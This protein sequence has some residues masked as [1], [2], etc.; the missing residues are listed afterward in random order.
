MHSIIILAGVF[1]VAAALYIF[2]SSR[3]D[4]QHRTYTSVR[5]GFKDADSVEVRLPIITFILLLTS[6]FVFIPFHRVDIPSITT[7]FLL[8]FFVSTFLSMWISTVIH[9]FKLGPIASAIAVLL[10]WKFVSVTSYFPEEA[11]QYQWMYGLLG[12]GISIVIPLFR[13]TKKS[14]PTESK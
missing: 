4:V 10:F 12:I 8:G 5:T 9:N 2:L 1:L 7:P 11:K 14:Q 13:K 6:F 3:R